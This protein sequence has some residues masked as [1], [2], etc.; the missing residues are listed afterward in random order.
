[1]TLTAM[2]VVFL[3]LLLLYLIFKQVGRSAIKMSRRRAEKVSGGRSVTH[4]TNEPGAVFAAIATALYEVA[5]DAHDFENTV[6]TIHRVARNYS[7]WSSKIY[8]LRS[9]PD[10]K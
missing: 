8:G 10:K 5:E 1:M 3:G 2:T 9:L 6:L 7:P 4:N